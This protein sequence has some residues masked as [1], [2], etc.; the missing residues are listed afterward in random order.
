MQTFGVNHFTAKPQFIW[1]VNSSDN[2]S[3]TIEVAGNLSGRWVDPEVASRCV[4]RPPPCMATTA[5]LSAGHI[6]NTM[7]FIGFCYEGWFTERGS[8]QCNSTSRQPP[9]VNNQSM[10]EWNV[11]AFDLN[12]Y[13]Q[14]LW[15]HHV[16]DA[17]PTLGS[18][19]ELS[20]P[21]TCIASRAHPIGVAMR[22]PPC[23]SDI[24]AIAR[25]ALVSRRVPPYGPSSPEQQYHYLAAQRDAPH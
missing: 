3:M 4:S 12:R 5:H 14:K 1:P 8:L 23:C 11:V 13:T 19:C 24:T 10:K 20:P 7:A 15:Q 6:S 21:H 17:G 16:T 25:I 18:A 9:D 22:V 2:S